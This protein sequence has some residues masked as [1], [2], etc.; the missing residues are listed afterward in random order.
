MATVSRVNASPQGS[1]DV[2]RSLAVVIR[3][4]LPAAFAELAEV[5][6]DLEHAGVSAEDMR[7]TVENKVCAACETL[8]VARRGVDA[9]PR[10][11]EGITNVFRILDVDESDWVT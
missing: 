10:L 1:V 8:R 3:A 9:G 6:R 2:V 7:A 4:E 11:E 5:T